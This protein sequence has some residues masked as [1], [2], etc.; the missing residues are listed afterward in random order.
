MSTSEAK[1]EVKAQ[2][3]R[4]WFGSLLTNIVYPHELEHYKTQIASLTTA[5]IA[6]AINDFDNKI[7]VDKLNTIIRDFVDSVKRQGTLQ[8]LGPIVANATIA[9]LDTKVIATRL[10]SIIDEILDRRIFAT[11]DFMVRGITVG[12]AVVINLLFLFLAFTA[13]HKHSGIASSIGTASIALVL[14]GGVFLYSMDNMVKLGFATTALALAA[15][16]YTYVDAMFGMMMCLAVGVLVFDD[17]V[18]QNL[19]TPPTA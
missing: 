12:I 18:Y 13:L 16:I 9:E 5:T 3:K 1:A 15:Y 2:E 11:Q 19:V 17:Y 14:F 6:K 10:N 7:A 8:Q 4:S